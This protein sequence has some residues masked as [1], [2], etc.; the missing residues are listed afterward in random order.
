MLATTLMHEPELLLLDEGETATFTFTADKA[1]VDIPVD[2]LIAPAI[3]V[4][5]VA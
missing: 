3:L 5:E 2:D 1:A 4:L